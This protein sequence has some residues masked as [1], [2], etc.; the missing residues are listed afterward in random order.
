MRVAPNY[1]HVQLSLVDSGNINILGGISWSHQ[2]HAA[3]RVNFPLT[4]PQGE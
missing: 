4:F 1:I 2:L 3:A